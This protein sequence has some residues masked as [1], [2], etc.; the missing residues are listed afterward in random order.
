LNITTIVLLLALV[1][2]FSP[3]ELRTDTP[4]FTLLTLGCFAVSLLLGMGGLL[5]TLGGRATAVSVRT[6]VGIAYLVFL[7][8]L[9]G[10][11]YVGLTTLGTSPSAGG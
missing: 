5:Y 3:K 6:I 2:D 11:L 8:G 1:R 7:L 9:I 10:A 4:A